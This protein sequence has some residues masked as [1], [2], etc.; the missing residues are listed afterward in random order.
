MR[1]RSFAPSIAVSAAAAIL[2]FAAAV[3]TVKAG[4]QNPPATK[5]AGPVPRL[6]D[7]KPDMTLD[8]AERDL[9]LVESIY[10]TLG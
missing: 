10:A 8:L 4:Q 7:G 5:P 3:P 9:K 1:K 6:T 2:V